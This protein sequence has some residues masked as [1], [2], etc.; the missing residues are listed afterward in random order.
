MALGAPVTGY[1]LLGIKASELEMA[2]GRGSAYTCDC[3]NFVL[4][5]FDPNIKHTGNTLHENQ[6]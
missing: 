1:L 3:V 4:C 2:D 5:A 6:I